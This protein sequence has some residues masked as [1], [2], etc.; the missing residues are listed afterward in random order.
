V[1]TSRRTPTIDSPS[2]EA[3]LDQVARAAS[4]AEAARAEERRL[5][6]ERDQAVLAAVRAGATLEE[7]AGAAGI[8][9]AAA[10]YIARRTLPPR[11]TRGGPYRR[12]RG[13]EAALETV[14]AESARHQQA[15]AAAGAATADRHQAILD[16]VAQGAGVRATARA[17]MLAPATVSR[18]VRSR[19]AAG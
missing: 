2:V 12:R 18:L 3:A 11:P 14:R 7:I 5:A 15:S 1:A 17:A 4:T 19:A 8:T 16:A 10:S 9:R 13:L 6:V